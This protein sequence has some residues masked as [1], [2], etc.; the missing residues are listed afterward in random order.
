MSSPVTHTYVLDVLALQGMDEHTEVARQIAGAL[1]AQLAAVG[2]AF[3]RL[4][5]E[6]EPSGYLAAL[7]AEKP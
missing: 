4:A 7:A 2:P 6:E 5:F 1:A 3:Q